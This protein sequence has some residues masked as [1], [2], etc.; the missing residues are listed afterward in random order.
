M[1]SEDLY[2]RALDA[3]TELFSDSSASIS[4]CRE[5]LESLQSEIDIL[6][7]SLPVDDSD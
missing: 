6:L 7:D 5:D 1:P 4:E 3:I 2:Q